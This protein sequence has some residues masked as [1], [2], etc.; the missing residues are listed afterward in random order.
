VK[1]GKK[2]ER[3]E[4]PK[5]MGGKCLSS[6]SISRGEGEK[7][8][9]RIRFQLGGRPC[10]SVEKKGRAALRAPRGKSQRTPSREREDNSSAGLIGAEKKG[11]GRMFNNVCNKGKRKRKSLILCLVKGGKSTHPSSLIVWG[12]EEMNLRFFTAIEGDIGTHSSA[13]AN[14]R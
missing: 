5:C 10:F 8:E 2:G 1:K 14:D 7:E 4:S 6:N 9:S 12:G 11:G 13:T 3:G